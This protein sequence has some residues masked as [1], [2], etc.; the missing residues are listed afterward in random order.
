MNISELKNLIS[1][2]GIPFVYDHWT[3]DDSENSKPPIPFGVFR[4]PESANFF[5]DGQ[6]YENITDV[7]VIIVTEYKD[8]TVEASI[9]KVLNDAEISWQKTET[10][11]EKERVYNIEYSFST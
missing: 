5:A 9:E 3:S 1:A 7:E 11:I 8:P 4:F 6:V 10:Y 2:S